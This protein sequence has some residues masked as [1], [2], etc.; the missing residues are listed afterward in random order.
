MPKN[1]V[2]FGPY[3][4]DSE[5]YELRREGTPIKLD[6]IPFELLLLLV[7]RPGKLV[8][9]QEAVDRVWGKDVFIEP[10]AALYTA[11]RKIRL[12]LDDD[13]A[14]PRYVRTV[15][16]KGYRFIAPVTMQSSVVVANSSVPPE[17]QAAA[18]ARPAPSM[19]PETREEPQTQDR[20]WGAVKGVETHTGTRV[21]TRW[22]GLV[23][24]LLV[25]LAAALAGYLRLHRSV[26]LTD[27]DVIVLADF[28]NA[29]S[30]PVFDDTLRQGLTVQLEQSPFLRVISDERIRQ[31]LR[32]MGQ[33]SDATLIPELAR[34]VCIRTGSAAV[35]EGSIASLGSQYVLGFRATNCHT[36]DV[37]DEEQVQAARKED[38][39]AALSRIA[40]NFRSR[41]GES[42]STVKQYDTPLAKATTPSLEAL[43]AYTAGLKINASSG[44]AAAVPFLQHAIE[45]DPKFAMAYGFLGRLYGDLDENVLSGENTRKAY[46]LRQRASDRERFWITVAYDI[47][48]TGNLDSAYQTCQIWKRAYPRD[49]DPHDYL[50]GIVDPPLGKFAEGREEAKEAIELNPEFA[51]S[52]WVLALNDQSLGQIQGAAVPLEQAAARKLEGPEL[53]AERYDNAFLRNDLSAMQQT[54]AQ[55]P[56]DDIEATEWISYH[57]ASV[58][59]YSGRLRQARP[60]F[61]QAADYALQTGQRERASLWL[62]GAGVREALL[63]N[64][65]EAKKWSAAALRLSKDREAEY[66]AAFALA[67]SGDSTRAQ[68]LAKDLGRRFPDD[69]TVQL[70]YLPVLRAQLALSFGDASKAIEFLRVAVR[71]ELGAPR[72]SIH[73]LFGALYPIYLRGEAYLAERRGQKAAA[74][75]Q[76]ILDHRGIVVSDPIGALA[77]LQLGRAYTLEAQSSQGV[78]AEAARAKARAAYRDFLTLWNHAD[79]D[80]PVLRQAK[81]EYASLQ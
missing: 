19:E 57:S 58:F 14:A 7:E 62:A 18:N 32:L 34:Q 44:P 39:L 42:L 9:H 2:R 37:I 56:D 38:V 61:A 55:A 71:D 76:K 78:D 27:Q 72:S 10:E 79:P 5:S 45:L 25:L 54:A 68:A 33:P 23:T 43:E 60:M 46:E 40:R 28:T 69:V 15:S 66:G 52:Y 24:A 31:T 80:I 16:H 51:V 29:T 49:D 21:G 73:A 50:A 47:Q 67:L 74:E 64:A 48:V 59:A 13:A 81:A 8:T 11:I 30:D 6:R 65:Q 22:K 53:W 63:G 36:G 35:L 77:H 12:A 20:N 1:V 17:E 26:K 41:V 75:F 4:L 70:S 3:E